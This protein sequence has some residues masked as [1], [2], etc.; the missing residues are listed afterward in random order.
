MR[1]KMETKLVCIPAYSM[2]KWLVIRILIHLKRMHIV[3]VVGTL[4]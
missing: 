1:S 4:L 3:Y 2:Y